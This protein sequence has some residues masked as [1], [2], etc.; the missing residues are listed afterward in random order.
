MLTL[1][2]AELKDRVAGLSDADAEDWATS[3]LGTVKRIAGCLLASDADTYLVAEAKVILVEAAKRARRSG[4]AAESDGP[5]SVSYTAGGEIVGLL[6][7]ADKAALQ[8]LCGSG[9]SGA[10]PLGSFPPAADYGFL[11]AQPPGRLRN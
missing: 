11:F 9:S 8:G 4:I 2:K 10:M 6:G 3:M 5:H 1:T 7:D